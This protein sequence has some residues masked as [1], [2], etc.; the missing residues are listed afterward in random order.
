MID[1]GPKIATSQPR[2]A[3][4][5][6]ARGSEPIIKNETLAGPGATVNYPVSLH[7]P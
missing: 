6:G 4:A 3:Q 7:V 1:L 5:I 2:V